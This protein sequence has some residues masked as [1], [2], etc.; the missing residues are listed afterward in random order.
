MINLNN[1][2]NMRRSDIWFFSVI[3]IAIISIPFQL[4]YPDLKFW[5]IFNTFWWIS[6]LPYV[7]IKIFFRKS[8]L[9]DWLNSE[10]NIW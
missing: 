5:D 4:Q 7:V 9:F 8:R 10:V 3:I 1:N 2:N 6:L